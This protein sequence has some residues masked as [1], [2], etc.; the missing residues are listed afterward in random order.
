MSKPNQ[1]YEQE[2][3]SSILE[4]QFSFYSSYANDIIADLEKKRNQE[5]ASAVKTL[6]IGLTADP[7]QSKSSEIQNHKSNH[8]PQLEETETY[9][10]DQT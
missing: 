4:Q 7:I 8:L 6:S 9:E 5:E 1:S 10:T 3:L 2:D